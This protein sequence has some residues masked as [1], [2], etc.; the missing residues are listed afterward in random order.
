MIMIKQSGIVMLT[1]DLTADKLEGLKVWSS[2]R[3]DNCYVKDEEDNYYNTFVLARNNSN[4]TE[5][6]ITFYPLSGTGKFT[7]RLLFQI[8]KRD[9]SIAV[10]NKN[11]DKTR[12]IDFQ[13]SEHG[14]ENFWNLISF[15]KS[16]KDV[17]DTGQ[18]DGEFNVVAKDEAVKEIRQSS[19]KEEDIINLSSEVGIP[20]EDVALYKQIK[21][22]ERHLEV[23]K[24]L[25]KDE[26]DYIQKYKS[27]HSITVGG[28]E[29]A[30]HHFLK[31]HQWVFGLSLDLRFIENFA[32][33]QSVGNPTTERN[34][35][36]MVDIV[37]FSDYTVLVELKTPKAKIFTKTKSSDARANT[38]SF[39]SKF[40]EGFS[41]CLGQKFDWDKNEISKKF[42][43]NNEH[44]NKLRVR[45]VDPK[46]IFL[47]GNK[48]EEIPRDSTD[49]D[50]ITKR[51]TF[52]RFVQNN[53]NVEFISYDELYRRAEFIVKG[54]QF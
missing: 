26:D 35:N 29:S 13:D 10:S 43:Q 25:L 8:V 18:F 41:Q 4:H 2:S 33:E 20:I 34:G 46:V 14:I 21:D 42:T 47:F 12:R 49:D 23:F 40:I 11:N 38:W 6:I 7:P 36:P 28:D 48:E 16:F 27:Y 54:K 45:T 52:E 37:G 30:W 3:G 9:G 1:K 53:R 51:D 19:T 22:R 15:L 17:V 24:L 31:E 44:I 32:D 39:S 50:I 5:C